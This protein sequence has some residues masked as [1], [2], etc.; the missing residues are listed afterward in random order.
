M[1]VNDYNGPGRWSRDAVLERYAAYTQRFGVPAPRDLTP[2]EHQERGRQWVYPVM[3]QVI[4]GIESDDPACVEIGVEFI[5]EDAS[6]PFGM[7]LKYNTARALRRATLNAEQSE[8]V[9]RRVVEMLRAGNLPREFRQ[10][11]KLAK[12]V[13]LGAWSFELERGLDLTNPWVR[14]YHEYLKEA[15]VSE[16]RA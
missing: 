13:G 4:A 5:E 11:A 6:F 15:P 3:E 8:R 2:R 10:Y 16:G 12:K 7:R 1:E 9:R 14:H